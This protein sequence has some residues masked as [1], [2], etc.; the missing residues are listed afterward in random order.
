MIM[1][2]TTEG[3]E[4]IKK[5]A[6]R[7]GIHIIATTITKQGAVLAESAGAQEVISK[8]LNEEEIK[9]IIKTKKIDILV[10]ATHPF[11]ADATRN[12]IKAAQMNKI[13]YIRLERPLTNIPENDLIIPVR[14]FKKAASKVMELDYNKNIRI[15]HLA[16]VMTLHYFTEIINPQRIIARILPS[17]YSI[18]KCLELGLPSEN[19]IAMQGIFSKNFNKTLMEEYDVTIIVTKESGEIG[20]T[21]SKIKA[22]LELN[23]PVIIVMRPEV[24]ELEEKIVFGDIDDLYMELNHL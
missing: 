11:A 10:D 7:E 12:A 21:Y 19:I 24:P 3:V 15:L 22:A 1:A 23:I 18:K 20:G 8:A 6:P 9:E 14:S 16:G 13:K 2:G 5:L 17:I 4:I